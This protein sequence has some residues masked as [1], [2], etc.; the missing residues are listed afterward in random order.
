MG[1]LARMLGRTQEEATEL[2]VEDTCPHT[3]IAPRWTNA[4]DMG[5]ADRASQ[6]ICEVCLQSF[7]PA[8]HSDLRRTEADRLREAM[9]AAER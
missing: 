2:S 7:T 4:D 6:F 8:E 9:H 1:L 5:H 3:A